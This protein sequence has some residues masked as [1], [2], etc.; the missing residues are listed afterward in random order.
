MRDGLHFIPCGDG[1][2]GGGGGGGCR[3]NIFKVTCILF[4]FFFFSCVIFYFN[5]FLFPCCVK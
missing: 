5:V 1:D 4:M 3:F 2:G